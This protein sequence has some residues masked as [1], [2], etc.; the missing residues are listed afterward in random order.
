MDRVERVEERVRWVARV[1][2]LPLEHEQIVPRGVQRGR[3]IDF[4]V[5]RLGFDLFETRGVRTERRD[6]LADGSGIEAW[7]LSVELVPADIRALDGVDPPTEIE[8]ALEYV[9]ESLA[10]ARA[11]CR[12]RSRIMACSSSSRIT[13]FM[14]LAAS[15]RSWQRESS[16][17][18]YPCSSSQHFTLDNP[19][20][21]EISI[22]C[23][24][25]KSPAGT[26][27]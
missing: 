25:P 5:Q 20:T 21:G 1:R 8:I 27:E 24:R 11:G 7:K 13:R 2:P 12:C 18:S 17:G 16:A 23:V 9:G 3:L 10:H 26:P 4:V 19:E 14:R 6:V 22:L 15:K